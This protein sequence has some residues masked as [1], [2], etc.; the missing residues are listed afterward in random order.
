MGFHGLVLVFTLKEIEKKKRNNKKRDIEIFSVP[1]GSCSPSRSPCYEG[2]PSCSPGPPCPPCPVCPLRRGSRR[3]R[4]GALLP[5]WPGPGSSPCPTWSRPSAACTC[6][7]RSGAAAACAPR[8][9]PG[10][11]YLSVCGRVA[12]AAVAAAAAGLSAPCRSQADP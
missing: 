8:L 1:S 6:Q 9:W 11:P 10:G 3:S 4:G 12:V 7:S 5:S 2:A